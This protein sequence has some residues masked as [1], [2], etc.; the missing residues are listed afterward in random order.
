MGDTERVGSPMPLDEEAVRAASEGR[1][2]SVLRER[3][4]IR[5]NEDEVKAASQGKSEEVIRKAQARA[6]QKT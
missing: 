4:P 6:A 2:E 5:L 1:G 3:Q